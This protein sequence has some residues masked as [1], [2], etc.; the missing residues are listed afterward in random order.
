ME[1]T[2]VT[3]EPALFA[4]SPVCDQIDIFAV[5][6]SQTNLLQKTFSDGTWSNWK[7]H[8]GLTFKSAPTAVIPDPGTLDLLVT[9]ASNTLY[10]RHYNGSVW[11]PTDSWFTLTDSVTAVGSAISQW[12]GR[13]DVYSRKLGNNETISLYNTERNSRRWF[14]LYYGGFI[15]KGPPVAI[16]TGRYTMDYFLLGTDNRIWHNHDS[17]GHHSGLS[18]IGDQTFVSNPSVVSISQGRV[19]IFAIASDRSAMHNSF[20]HVTNETDG[21]WTGWERLKGSFD[22]PL[23]A[24]AT[25]ETNTIHVFGLSSNG[26]LWHREGNGSV[27]PGNW[28][29]HGGSF[30]NVP[31]AVSSCRDTIDVFGVGGDAALWH[32]RRGSTGAWT[33][34]LNKWESLQGS[35]RV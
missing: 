30:L 17:M 26:A 35:I 33:P 22:S 10:H 15:A 16:V 9:D 4:I 27:W 8:G 24:V 31:V 1:Q 14:T 28:Q 34:G 6:S 32:Q 5:N 12:A 3:D 7:Q 13:I 25:K 29:S 18:S 19:D 21:V 11:T 23:S 20:Q 2:S